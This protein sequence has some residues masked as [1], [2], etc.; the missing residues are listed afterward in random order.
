MHAYLKTRTHC[1]LERLLFLNN[2]LS[3]FFLIQLE[4]YRKKFQVYK[5]FLKFD[6]LKYSKF[7]SIF[8]KNKIPGEITLLNLIL[9]TAANH[10]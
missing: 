4:P 10:C 8:P 1:I 6:L 7:F 3:F 2:F 5:S 9:G